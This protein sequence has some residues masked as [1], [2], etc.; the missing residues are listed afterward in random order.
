VLRCEFSTDAAGL[1]TQFAVVQEAPERH[2]VLRPHQVRVG[3]YARTGDSLTRVGGAD[4]DVAGARTVVPSLLGTARPDLILLN[5]DDTGYLIVRF[6]PR[7]LATVLSSVGGLPARA[8]CWNTVIDMVRQAEL[9]VSAFAA[10]LA[11][12]MRSEKPPVL[13]A[14]W[15][16]AYW[17]ITRFAAPEQAAETRSLPET[18]AAAIPGLELDPESRWTALRRLAAAGKA[19]DARIDAELASDPSDAG[20]RN[21]AACRAAIP[22]GRHKEAAWRLLASETAERA[23]R[24]RALLTIRD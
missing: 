4:V 23:L 8:V 5:D 7:S 15:Q 11:R 16:Q 20:R 24:A 10:M 3:L 2:P 6:D 18:A 9:P 22:D 17:L 14:L 21:A 13:S 12:A 1:F 19:D